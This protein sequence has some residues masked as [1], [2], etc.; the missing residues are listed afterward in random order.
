KQIEFFYNA[1]DPALRIR[2][3][4][5]IFTLRKRQ[6]GS[7]TRLEHVDGFGAVAAGTLS[8]AIAARREGPCWRFVQA[9]G[10]RR[11]GE[12][13]ATQLAR[14]FRAFAAVRSTAEMAQIPL[15]GRDRGNAAWQELTAV[16]GIGSVVAAAVAAFFAEEHNRRVVDELLAEVTPID[17]AAVAS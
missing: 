14:A 6:A 15:E 1:E 13:N 2:S 4:A 3:P 8:G 5:D 12:T 10:I 7:L 9:R 17:E 11:V 16:E